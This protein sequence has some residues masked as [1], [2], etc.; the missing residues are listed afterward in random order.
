[1]ERR[2]D[3]LDGQKQSLYE[4]VLGEI[5]GELPYVLSEYIFPAPAIKVQTFKEFY[6]HRRDL[7]RFMLVFSRDSLTYEKYRKTKTQ[8]ESE[9]IFLTLVKHSLAVSPIVLTANRLPYDL[10]KEIQQ[11]IL[12][13]RV[14]VTSEKKARFLTDIFI[15]DNIGEKEFV[16]VSNLPSRRSVQNIDH[17]H[18]F[19]HHK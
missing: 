9:N 13:Y 2:K 7:Q 14:G 1:M 10:P 5:P 17:Y 4:A 18:I 11:Y 12:W 8:A 6:E 15:K 3:Y 16:I 19:T